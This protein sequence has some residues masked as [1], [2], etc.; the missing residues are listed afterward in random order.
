MGDAEAERAIAFVAHRLRAAVMIA[1]GQALEGGF[2]N[3]EPGR[4]RVFAVY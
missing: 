1:P 2:D 3:S 4:S